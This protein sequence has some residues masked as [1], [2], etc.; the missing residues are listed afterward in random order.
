MNEDIGKW[1]NWWMNEWTNKGTNEWM[2][3]CIKYDY[4]GERNID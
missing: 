3:E 4:K 2:N 1:M